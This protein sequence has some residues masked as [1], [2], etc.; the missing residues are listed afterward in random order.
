MVFS[1]I[2]V[3]SHVR[4]SPTP[5][6]FIVIAGFFQPELVKCRF[7]C[8]CGTVWRADY[9]L[10]LMLWCPADDK[11]SRLK[12]WIARRRSTFKRQ[13]TN[14]LLVLKNEISPILTFR[15]PADDR[16]SFPTF[17]RQNKILNWSF[18]ISDNNI[19]HHLHLPVK[20]KKKP[21]HLRWLFPNARKVRPGFPAGIYLVKLQSEKVTGVKRVVIK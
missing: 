10:K 2:W 14:T 8:L 5:N 18:L 13:K 7:D 3:E 12:P 6:L 4:F 1:P 20:K 15:C 9:L 21:L 11:R 17:K 19:A 16:K